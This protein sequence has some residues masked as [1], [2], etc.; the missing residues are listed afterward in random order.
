M[1]EFQKVAKPC[2]EYID[3]YAPEVEIAIL[4]HD[5]SSATWHV[6]GA[7]ARKLYHLIFP[8]K[9]SGGKPQK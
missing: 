8:N 2:T 7:I 9:D 3:D 1:L 6:Y 5:L 4:Q